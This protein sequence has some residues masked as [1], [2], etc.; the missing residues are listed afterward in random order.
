VNGVPCPWTKL[1]DLGVARAAGTGTVTLVNRGLSA[2]NLDAVSNA[3]R[4]KQNTDRDKL[5]QMMRYGQSAQCRWA[6]L[7]EYFGERL[8]EPCGTCDNCRHPLEQQIAPPA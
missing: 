8:A 7:L 2:D 1:K 4:E 3:Y 5:D 6:Q